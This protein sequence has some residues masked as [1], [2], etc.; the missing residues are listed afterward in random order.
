MTNAFSR[1]IMYNLTEPYEEHLHE[2]YLKRIE[3]NTRAKKFYQ[4][5]KHHI[6]LKGFYCKACNKIKP[7]Y[8]YTLKKRVQIWNFVYKMY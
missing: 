1:H 8:C 6:Q 2:N 7:L 5:H 4:E 3:K